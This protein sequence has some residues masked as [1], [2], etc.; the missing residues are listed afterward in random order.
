MITLHFHSLA[1]AAATA[2]ALVLSAPA[3][4]TTLGGALTAD[5]E[6]SAYLSSDDS[7]LGAL[8]AS[9]SDWGATYSLPSTPIGA[10]TS[11]LHIVATDLGGPAALI[12][13]FAL[14]DAGASFS[15]G[16]QSLLTNTTNW[17]VR[18]GSF[19]GADETPVSLGTNGVGP[20]GFRTGIASSAE[21]IW[22]SDLCSSCTRYFSTTMTAAVPE[23]QTYALLLGGL[24]ALGWV[25]RRS[26]RG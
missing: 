14:S 2:C 22:D 12:G 4:A 8:L 17:V 1:A 19:A 24:A 26:A 21:W 18:T 5:N 25:A 7:M 10:G 3:S 15:N 13:D 6:F 11:Y 20:W 9:G 16:G 23:P